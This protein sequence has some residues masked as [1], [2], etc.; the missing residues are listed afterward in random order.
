M[1]GS[2]LNSQQ[3]QEEVDKNVFYL[4]NIYSKTILSNNKYIFS[5]WKY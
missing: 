4:F 5:N 1:E 2:F 3:L